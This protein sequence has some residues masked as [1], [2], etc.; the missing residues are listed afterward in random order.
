LR[1]NIPASGKVRLYIG[2]LGIERSGRQAFTLE[3]LVA[4]AC[5]GT[6]EDF[7]PW[8]ARVHGL[9]HTRRIPRA[10]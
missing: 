4:I 7:G 9:V 10:V 6:G 1:L 3:G 5:D 8:T 2:A